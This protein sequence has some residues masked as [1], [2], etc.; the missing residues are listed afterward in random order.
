MSQSDG[1]TRVMGNLDVMTRYSTV[2]AQ[3]AEEIGRHGAW[4]T[5]TVTAYNQRVD[6]RYR[7]VRNG[8]P[9]LA[10]SVGLNNIDTFVGDIAQ[11]LRNADT[12]SISYE[13]ALQAVRARFG[14]AADLDRTAS[15]LATG[16]FV[17]A[18]DTLDNIRGGKADSTVSI[19]D[20]KWASKHATDPNTRA[21]AVWLLA[22]RAV[23]ES[24]DTANQTEP[25]LPGQLRFGDGR[26]TNA[27]IVTFQQRQRAYRVMID[28]FAVF[29]GAREGKLDG[30]VS[31]N[32]LRRMA[33]PPYPA[34][35]RE[36]ARVLASDPRGLHGYASFGDK[37]AGVYDLDTVAKTYG[38]S[39]L[40]L[41]AKP[42][43][44]IINAVCGVAGVYSLVGWADLVI[45]IYD[46]DPEKSVNALPTTVGTTA[47]AIG[48]KQVGKKIAA[49]IPAATAKQAARLATAQIATK[50]LAKVASPGVAFTAAATGIDL[51]CRVNDPSTRTWGS[52]APIWQYT[53]QPSTGT[54]TTS[55]P[56]TPTPSTL[57]PKLTATSVPTAT[58]TNQPKG[59]QPTSPI[60]TVPTGTVPTGTEPSSVGQ[61]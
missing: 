35:L 22:H 37:V 9:V 13:T 60:G 12:L 41:P 10:L 58:K 57:A 18:F 19:D 51:A 32:D 61:G 30:K 44:P 3:R 31:Q 4:V 7:V 6:K 21:A 52:V 16:V 36:A 48:G 39:R 53:S 56:T 59:G 34:D 49:A 11:R 1:S 55:T 14:T 46:H 43:N 5:Q 2:G 26:I 24:I 40:P 15:D 25:V 29:D 17:D 8:E 28:N 45:G 50:A 38:E 27:D 54:T 47:I 23:L 33:Y 20:L 42:R